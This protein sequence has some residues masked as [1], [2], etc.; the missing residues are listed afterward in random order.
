MHRWVRAALAPL[1][2]R[3]ANLASRAVLR[4]LNDAAAVQRVQVELLAGEFREL[5][6]VQEYGFTSV[7]LAGAHPVVVLA[8]FGNRAQALA[9][10]VDDVRYRPSGSAPGDVVIYDS[11]GTKIHLKAGVLDVTVAGNLTI[12]VSG[13][14]KIVAP[15]VE[16]GDG[17]LRKLCDERLIAYLATH[18]HSGVTPGVGNTGT[19]TAV[20]AVDTHTTVETKGS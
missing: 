11:R 7:P 5:Q 10:A 14:A 18:V 19:P 1:H 17:T 16:L 2:Q 4:L 13:T 8:P 9:I 15:A 12:N 20:P 6:R 3:V